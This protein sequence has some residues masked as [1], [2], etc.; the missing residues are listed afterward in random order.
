M[1]VCVC[2]FTHTHTNIYI[3]SYIKRRVG[4]DSPE[5]W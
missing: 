4:N 1:C 3:P 5:D 2:V